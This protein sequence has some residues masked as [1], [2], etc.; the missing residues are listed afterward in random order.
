MDRLQRWRQ[1]ARQGSL[2]DLIWRIYSETGYLDWVGGLPGGKRRQ[3]NLTAL[4][5]RAVQYEQDTASRGL[6]R[7]LTFISRLRER[8]GISA[9]PAVRKVR[10]TRCA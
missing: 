2:S 5:D 3:G 1:E 4:Y 6:F 8:G 9:R 7:F 10:A